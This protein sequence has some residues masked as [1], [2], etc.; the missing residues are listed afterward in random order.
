MGDFGWLTLLLAVAS[1]SEQ[2]SA[3]KTLY[4]AFRKAKLKKS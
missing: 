3:P 4:I 2:L 1:P